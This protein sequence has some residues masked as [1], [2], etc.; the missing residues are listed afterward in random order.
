MA[1]HL[2]NTLIMF[3]IIT[4]AE[5]YSISTFQGLQKELQFYIVTA[6]VFI[7][8]SSTVYYKRPPSL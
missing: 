7:I 5:I 2:F 4:C 8:N 6:I 1:I 3:I